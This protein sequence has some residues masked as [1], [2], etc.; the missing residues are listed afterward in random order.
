ME[1]RQHATRKTKAS[2]DKFRILRQVQTLNN[3]R[4]HL[5]GF[6]CLDLALYRRIFDRPVIG[7]HL[8]LRPCH[9]LGIDEHVRLRG[10]FYRRN[11]DVECTEDKGKGCNQSNKTPLALDEISGVQQRC[12]PSLCMISKRRIVGLLTKLTGKIHETLSTTETPAVSPHSA[13]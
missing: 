1:Q 9:L 4:R 8:R 10:I 2:P 7:C 3:H 12:L 6:S 13:K 5:F 11:C